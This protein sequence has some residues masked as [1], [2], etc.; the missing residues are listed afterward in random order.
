M[1]P[2]KVYLSNLPFALSSAVLAAALLDSGFC[3]SN[4]IV[5]NKGCAAE[6]RLA[7]A[8][9]QLATMDFCEPKCFA[10]IGDKTGRTNL[11]L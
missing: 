10:L 1:D 4:V 6:A 9:V 11:S 7:S 8:L 3:A 5:F 2:F